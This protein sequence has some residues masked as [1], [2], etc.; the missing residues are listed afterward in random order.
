MTA[1]NHL[2]VIQN[3]IQYMLR[4]DNQE[5]GNEDIKIGMKMVE[6]LIPDPE[7]HIVATSNRFAEDFASYMKRPYRVLYDTMVIEQ[8]KPKNVVILYTGHRTDVQAM[9]HKRIVKCLDGLPEC[10]RWH[11]GAWRY[12]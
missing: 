1:A 5:V 4:R 8:I 2:Y 11:I 6:L 12:T 9:Q 3:V 7:L 10:H